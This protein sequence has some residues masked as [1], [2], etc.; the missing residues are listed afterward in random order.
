MRQ[1]TSISQPEDW[2]DAFK[3]EAQVK[4]MSLSE[5]MG[6]CCI[7]QLPSHVV[8]GLSTREPVGKRQPKKEEETPL[9][10]KEMLDYS[11]P[12]YIVKPGDY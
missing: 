11:D 9:M 10:P 3:H 12:D 1:V 7:I 8:D 6:Q 2:W 4:G 5:W